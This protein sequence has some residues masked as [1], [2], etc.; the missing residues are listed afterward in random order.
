MADQPARASWQRSAGGSSPALSRAGAAR[1]PRCVC[2]TRPGGA[3]AAG[4]VRP[5]RELIARPTADLQDQLAAVERARRTDRAGNCSCLP[6][7]ERRPHP[8]RAPVRSSRGRRTV[9]GRPASRPIGARAPPPTQ[10][11]PLG[12]TSA[13]TNGNL[14]RAAATGHCRHRHPGQSEP[15]DHEPRG[16]SGRR[17]GHELLG[18]M[19]LHRDPD[20]GASAGSSATLS[21]LS[22][23]AVPVYLPS[24][25]PSRP[26]P[27]TPR[28]LCA[29]ATGPP[30]GTGSGS[31]R[32]NAAG[33]RGRPER[34]P[35]SPAS[36]MCS[37]T[38]KPWSSG[39]WNS[40]SAL[41]SWSRGTRTR[42]AMPGEPPPRDGARDTPAATP[43]RRPGTADR[44]GSRRP[45][46]PGRSRPVGGRLPASGPRPPWHNRQHAPSRRD[47]RAGRRHASPA[48]GA[49]PPGVG[50]RPCLA[51]RS[52]S[53]FRATGRIRRGSVATAG[54]I[55]GRSGTDTDPGND[56][57]HGPAR[58]DR[59]THP[60]TS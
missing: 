1:K 55:R 36:S 19:D 26:R 46:H 25:R 60:P 47:A 13:T 30:S 43:R 23:R 8:R 17:Q 6:V 54:D 48:F 53:D 38:S 20:L 42:I 9:Q 59:V 16:Q 29:P 12:D 21:G 33:R 34:T 35:A 24:I 14:I 50:H 7:R 22:L 37:R 39:F 2:S 27:P 49:T 58:P 31:A 40:N 11:R 5:A 10:L 3:E 28:R 45:H 41:S 52:P 44:S 57:D 32:G 15:V 51:G 4:A 56:R 18:L